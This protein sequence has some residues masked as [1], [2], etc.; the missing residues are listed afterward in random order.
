MHYI[1]Y[2]LLQSLM[3]Q[4]RSIYLYIEYELQV[5]VIAKNQVNRIRKEIRS[6]DFMLTLILLQ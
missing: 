2:L 6:L 4:I 1:L 3:I 5:S